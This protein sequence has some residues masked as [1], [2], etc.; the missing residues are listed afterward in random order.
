VMLKTLLVLIFILRRDTLPVLSGLS[1]MKV[2]TGNSLYFDY[3]G[4]QETEIAAV[5]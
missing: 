1:Q 3:R 2:M 5:G 4:F